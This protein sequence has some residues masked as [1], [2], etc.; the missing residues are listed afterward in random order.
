MKCVG[1]KFKK[2]DKIRNHLELKLKTP[3]FAQL[4]Q[5]HCCCPK[6]E[7]AG[8]ETTGFDASQARFLRQNLKCLFKSKIQIDLQICIEV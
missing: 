8:P 5:L 3:N 4:Y 2:F 6:N 1:K 7:A